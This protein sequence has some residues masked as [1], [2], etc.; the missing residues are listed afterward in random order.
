MTPLPVEAQPGLG[1]D[2]GIDVPKLYQQPVDCLGTASS[3]TKFTHSLTLSVPIP[4]M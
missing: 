3:G 1:L 4:A 2:M